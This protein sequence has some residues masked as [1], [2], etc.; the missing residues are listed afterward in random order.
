ML[1]KRLVHNTANC[2]TKHLLCCVL[3]SCTQCM[4]G[5]PFPLEHC[6]PTSK[7]QCKH[8]FINESLPYTY[9]KAAML[10]ITNMYLSV[11]IPTVRLGKLQEDI[12]TCINRVCMYNK[13]VLPLKRHKNRWQLCTVKVPWVLRMPLLL[14]TLWQVSVYTSHYL[15][16]YI[17]KNWVWEAIWLLYDRYSLDFRNFSYGST[18]NLHR[19]NICPNVFYLLATWCIQP[20]FP[21][22]MYKPCTSCIPTYVYQ[23][24]NQSTTYCM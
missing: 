17:L 13:V 4:N 10:P 18:M 6:T 7:Q 23:P 19:H 1:R 14:I 9:G 15:L 20:H 8:H 24:Q 16:M 5:S 11:H 21:R 12:S 2:V 3:T 22:I